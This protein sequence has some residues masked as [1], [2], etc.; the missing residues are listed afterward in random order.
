MTA[1]TATASL[2]TRAKAAAHQ[3]ALHRIATA[4]VTTDR[5]RH[6]PRKI[7][8]SQPFKHAPAD[9]TTT[10]TPATIHVCGADAA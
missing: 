5:N 2:P 10:T 1:G 8:S 4:R 7:K 6:R 3:A 9:I